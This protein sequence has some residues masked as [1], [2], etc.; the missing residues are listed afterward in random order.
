MMVGGK[1]AYW[2]EGHCL[3]F[4]DTYEHWAVNNTDE[5]RAVLF[6]DVLKPLPR[7]LNWLNYFIVYVSRVF[8]YVFIPWFRHKRWE[9]KFF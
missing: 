5:L 6:M 4:D 2:R 3:F 1:R 9:R 8:P 7:P